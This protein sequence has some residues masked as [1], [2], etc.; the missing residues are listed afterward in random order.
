MKESIVFTIAFALVFYANGAG[1]IE[2][3]VNYSSWHLIGTAE[4]VTYH[5][6][7]TP[8]VLAFLVVPT[9][10]ATV[11]CI[12]ML[13]F[14]PPSIPAWSVWLV[15]ALQA[16]LWISSATIQ[17]PIQFKLQAQGL[18]APLIDHLI[19]TNLWLRRVPNILAAA[20]FLWMMLTV[21]GK[22]RTPT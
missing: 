18:S 13:R 22:G 2:G 9:A 15:I 17:I 6:F 8:R 12:L 19:V 7:I 21:L 5:K 4:F 11:F 14:R 3:F 16:V 1:S 20:I 10:L